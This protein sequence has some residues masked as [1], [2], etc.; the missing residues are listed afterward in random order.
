MHFAIVSNVTNKSN[1]LKIYSFIH[2]DW[3]IQ[4]VMFSI[5]GATKPYD[6]DSITLNTMVAYKYVVANLSAFSVL[7]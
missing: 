4:T 2:Y 6:H 1:V 7:G 3:F 5:F